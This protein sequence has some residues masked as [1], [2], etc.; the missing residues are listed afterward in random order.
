METNLIMDISKIIK[1]VI[2]KDLFYGLFLSTIEK[3]EEKSIPTAAVCVNKS[4][5]DFS[6]LINPDWWAKWSDNVKYGIMVHEAKML[7]F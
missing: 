3:R 4:T 7:G 5:M 1:K 6:L 2:I